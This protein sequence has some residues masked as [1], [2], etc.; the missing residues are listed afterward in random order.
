MSKIE[1]LMRLE[2]GE[3]FG[4]IHHAEYSAGFMPVS[5]ASRQRGFGSKVKVN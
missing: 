4:S 5:A 3:K 2:E 1:H